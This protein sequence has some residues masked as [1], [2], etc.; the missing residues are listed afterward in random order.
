MRSHYTDREGNAFQSMKVEGLVSPITDQT[1]FEERWGGWYVTGTYGNQPHRGNKFAPQSMDAIGDLA[2]AADRLNR[3][4]GANLTDL[5]S[6]LDTRQYLTPHS[7]IVALMV[8]AHQ[9]RVQ[10]LMVTAAQ[11]GRS[12]VNITKDSERFS[13]QCYSLMPLRCPKPSR[14]RQRSPPT[15]LPK[16]HA[17]LRAGR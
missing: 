9:V 3:I 4:T 16:D 2:V 7:D 6:R 12:G 17:T 14:A 10:N 8:L 5:G 13:E 11:A 1:A 15:S